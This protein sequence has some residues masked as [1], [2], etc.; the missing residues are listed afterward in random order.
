MVTGTGK[1]GG[2]MSDSQTVEKNSRPVGA[3]IPVSAD[4]S[5]SFM[6]VGHVTHEG[7]AKMI[8]YLKLIQGSFPH[9]KKNV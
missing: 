1:A 6:A 8:E 3:S 5:M 2:V 4:C 9:D 7:I